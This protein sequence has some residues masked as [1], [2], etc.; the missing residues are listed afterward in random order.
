[1][2][3]PGLPDYTP[4]VPPGPNAGV[5][6][7]NVPAYSHEVHVLGHAVVHDIPGMLAGIRRAAPQA[8]ERR[9]LGHGQIIVVEPHHQDDRDREQREQHR[10]EDG[11][12]ALA[13]RGREI[14]IQAPAGQ[15]RDHS[16]RRHPRKVQP[17]PRVHRDH[18]WE[19]ERPPPRIVPVP[20]GRRGGGRR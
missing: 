11:L 3:T 6:P 8:S 19:R 2:V 18:R 16:L 7:T 9:A 12:L 15:R 5:F 20:E 1:M 4:L 14:L 17:R 10:P 13:D